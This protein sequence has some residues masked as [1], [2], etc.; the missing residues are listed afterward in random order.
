[1]GD[2]N[3]NVSSKQGYAPNIKKY[4]IHEETNDDGYILQWPGVW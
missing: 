3:V 1:V 4:S 2:F